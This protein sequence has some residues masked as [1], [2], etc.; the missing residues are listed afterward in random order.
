[1]ILVAGGA[2]DPH[3]A[4]VIAAL[5]RR[6]APCTPLLHGPDAFPVVTLDVPGAQ[7][8]VDGRAVAPDALWVRHDVFHALADP[9]RAVVARA[10]AW[11]DT[12]V[13]WASLRPEVWW[14]NRAAVTRRVDKIAQL[15]AAAKVGLRIPA[16][17]VTNDRA[18]LAADAAGLVAKPVSG[19]GLCRSVVGLLDGRPAAPQPAFV[20]TRLDGPEVRAYVVGG[21]VLAWEILTDALDHRADPRAPVRRVALPDPERGLL[22]TLARTLGLDFAAADLK[23]DPADGALVFLEIN[24][25]PMWTAYDND[26]GGEL[27]DAIVDLLL[28]G[29]A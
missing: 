9:R 22:L 3:Q 14:P 29:R 2:L 4:R 11:F 6:G 16:T 27:V 24:T 1:M 21:R 7:L 8:V 23:R 10:Q 17:R 18:A 15:G 12:I 13:G 26:C 20:Q 5:A 28:D 25:Q 19:G